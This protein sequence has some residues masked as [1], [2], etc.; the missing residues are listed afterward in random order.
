[1]TKKKK[2]LVAVVCCVVFLGLAGLVVSLAGRVP[3]DFARLSDKQTLDYLKSGKAKYL[4]KDNLLKLGTR[5]EQMHAD[6]GLWRGGASGV[7]E[8]E[9]GKMRESR[10][11]VSE[12]KMNKTISDFFALPVDQQDAFLDTQIMQMDQRMHQFAGR[13]PPGAGNASFRG[14]TR[15]PNARLQ[16]MRNMLSRTTPEERAERSEYFRRLMARR[17]ATHGGAPPFG[18]R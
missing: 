3:P 1:M 6:T 15:D 4:G 10:R 16:M 17:A 14:R 7:S 13:R 11:L 12:A 9:R 8:K 5:L 2:I 18:R